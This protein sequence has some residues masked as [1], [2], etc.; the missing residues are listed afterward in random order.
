MKKLLVLLVFAQFAFSCKDTS[1]SNE[2]ASEEP[3][4]SVNET[5]QEPTS[6]NTPETDSANAHYMPFT[7]ND[8]LVK[9][10]AD[11]LKND[12]LKSDYDILMDNDKKFQLAEIDLNSDGKN[13]VFVNFFSSYFCGTGGCTLLLLSNDLKPI[14]KFTVTRTPLYIQKEVENG[15]NTIL[16]RFGDKF[17]KLVNNGK[18]YPNN[19][20]VVK[21]VDYAP[22]GHDLLLFD[23]NYSPSKTYTF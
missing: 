6:K 7:V 9:N 2:K 5:S 22:S 8:A 10:I 15:W 13:E 19:P 4:G 14:T 17:V 11:F 1:K 23:D 21:P 20:S 18:T 12:Y 16:V 3:A